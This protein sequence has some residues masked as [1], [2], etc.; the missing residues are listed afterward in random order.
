MKQLKFITALLIGMIAGTIDTI[1]MI[2]QG[3]DLYACASAYVHWVVLGLIIPYIKWDMRAWLKGLIVAELCLLPVLFI[4]AN[5]EPMSIIPM[6]IFSTVLGP[7]VG[8][9]GKRFVEQKTE[10]DFE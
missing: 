9:A 6:I 8:M 10:T 4:V 2:L 1:P 3:I 5:Q 7:L